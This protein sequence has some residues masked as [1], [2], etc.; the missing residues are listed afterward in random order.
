MLS[1]LECERSGNAILVIS[2]STTVNL[3]IWGIAWQIQQNEVCQAKTQISLGVCPVWSESSL[4]APWVAKDPRLLHTDSKDSDQTG[5]IFACNF[6]QQILWERNFCEIRKLAKIYHGCLWYMRMT[7]AHISTFV[8]CFLGSI[9]PVL[10][11]SE[12]SGL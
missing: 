12:I 2:C 1:C 5:Q 4:C 9:I 6:Y 11:T 10:A 8:V 3:F 7:E